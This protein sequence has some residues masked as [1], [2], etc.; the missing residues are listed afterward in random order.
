MEWPQLVSGLVL[1]AVLLVSAVV[2]AGT[3]VRLL[4]GPVRTGEMP[5]EER[6][7]GV[8]EC[9]EQQPRAVHEARDP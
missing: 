8:E 5:D 4:R 6:R 9:G 1:T 7:Q 2:F 3:Q